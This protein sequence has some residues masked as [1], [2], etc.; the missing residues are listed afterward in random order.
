M[1]IISIYFATELFRRTAQLMSIRGAQLV[2]N[3]VLSTHQQLTSQP[4]LSL[5]F[6][7]LVQKK[8]PQYHSTICRCWMSLI[9]TMHF[10]WAE[11]DL[12]SKKIVVWSPDLLTALLYSFCD[13]ELMISYGVAELYT[14]LH[15]AYS[16]KIHLVTSFICC[17]SP[18]SQWGPWRSVC[19]W[20]KMSQICIYYIKAAECYWL[21]HYS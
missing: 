15:I 6:L 2:R 3:L 7:M 10:G 9:K 16:E 5:K 1:Q 14:A 4:I 20:Q 19:V 13:S 8:I 18:S 12:K 17:K 11:F 21:R